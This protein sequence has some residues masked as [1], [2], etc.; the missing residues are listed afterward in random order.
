MDTGEIPRHFL[1]DRTAFLPPE[2]ADCI[3]EEPDAFKLIEEGE[4]RARFYKMATQVCGNCALMGNCP[5]EAI[6]FMGAQ[7]AV[8]NGVVVESEA[9][10]V[11]A[12][13]TQ[14]PTFVFPIGRLPDSQDAALR[15]IR[16][17]Y[18]A[19][20]LEVL[21]GRAG[22]AVGDTFTNLAEAKLLEITPTLDTTEV[23]NLCTKLFGLITNDRVSKGVPVTLFLELSEQ[24]AHDATRLKAAGYANPV[25]LAL[26]HHPEIF[27][28]IGT[29]PAYEREET[30]TPFMAPD[31]PL[32][33]TRLSVIKKVFHDNLSVQAASTLDGSQAEKAH[34]VITAQLII[35]ASNPEHLQQAPHAALEVAHRYRDRPIEDILRMT[36]SLDKLLA[37]GIIIIDP[38]DTRKITDNSYFHCHTA[39]NALSEGEREALLAAYSVD[40]LVYGTNKNIDPALFRQVNRIET[41][42]TTLIEAART[43]TEKLEA[44]RQTLRAEPTLLRRPTPSHFEEFIAALTTEVTPTEADRFALRQLSVMIHYWRPQARSLSVEA[45]QQLFNELAPTLLAEVAA[46]R[47]LIDNLSFAVSYSPGHLGSLMTEFIPTKEITKKDILWA[48]R[49]MRQTAPRDALYTF[50]ITLETLRQDDWPLPMKDLEPLK[51]AA[52]SADPVATMKTMQSHLKTFKEKYPN[53]RFLKEVDFYRFCFNA[54]STAFEQ[55]TIFIRTCEEIAPKFAND[56]E[57]TDRG[58]RIITRRHTASPKIVLDRIAELKANLRRVRETY[59]DCEELD[60]ETL[61][62]IANAN[63]FDVEKSAK[64]WLYRYKT[65]V[66]RF[67]D[68]IEPWVLKECLANNLYHKD[69]KLIARIRLYDNFLHTSLNTATSK[70]EEVADPSRDKRLEDRSSLG[71]NPARALEDKEAAVARL[72]HIFSLVETLAPKERMAVMEAYQI[73]WRTEETVAMTTKEIQS[74]FQTQDL[75][76]YVDTH[77]MPRLRQAAADRK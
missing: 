51:T 12:A 10:A 66:K 20:T 33:L 61:I 27:E 5:E 58:L 37:Q 41:R 28:E 75:K 26:R 53:H 2:I 46:T 59:S 15:F 50:M 39:L 34:D 72:E 24:V 8:F 64:V 60:E 4:R 73:D 57:L 62:T 30:R 1:L 76:A 9:S 25:E 71:I 14:E 36:A 70:N 3:A 54:P 63:P 7:I 55:A 6:N 77:I 35:T 32:F 11:E 22:E 67:G 40:E 13:R 45:E 21:P 65:L 18:R 47:S 69:R 56:P 16:M 17:H 52:R 31:N 68:E 48:C 44:L 29:P 19:G 42:A 49:R 43:P 23:T 38:Q 74:H